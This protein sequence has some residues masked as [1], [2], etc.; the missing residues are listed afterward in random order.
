MSVMDNPKNRMANFLKIHYFNLPQIAQI[1][2]DFNFSMDS[3]QISGICGK[4]LTI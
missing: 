3:A 1:I 4:I 2:A